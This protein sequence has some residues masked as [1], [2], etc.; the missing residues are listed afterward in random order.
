[1][2]ASWIPARRGRRDAALIAT[3]YAGGLRRPEL[4]ALMLE[5]AMP[6]GELRVRHGKGNKQRTIYLESGA[7]AALVA[8]MAVRGWWSPGR[9]I[10]TMPLCGQAVE[11]IL[12][13]RGREASVSKFT[14]QRSGFSDLLKRG[15]DLVAVQAIR[16][17]QL[18]VNNREMRSPPGSGR[19]RRRR[20]CFTF[21]L[22][23][24]K[25]KRDSR[26]GP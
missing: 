1:M 4:A 13:K 10:S 25:G 19:S 20:A 16:R 8:W 14:P 12:R 15:A 7:Q 24:E 22:A 5:D 9:S 26:P 23:P 11:R 3:L 17:P 18:P 2:P 21:R 6:G